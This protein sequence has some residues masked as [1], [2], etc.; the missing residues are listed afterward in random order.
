MKDKIALKASL[1]FVSFAIIFVIYFLKV[2]YMFFYISLIF[3]A[4]GI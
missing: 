4:I 2:F 1:L 3:I